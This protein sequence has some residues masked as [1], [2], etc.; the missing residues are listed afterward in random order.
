MKKHTTTRL[1]SLYLNVYPPW[2]NTADGWKAKPGD[3]TNIIINS[4]PNTLDSKSDGVKK[5][6]KFIPKKSH[7]IS[8]EV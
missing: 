7:S 8:D 1:W 4:V 2:V 3:T 5:V 6:I